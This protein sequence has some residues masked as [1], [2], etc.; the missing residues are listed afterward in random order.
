[1]KK[2]RN[3]RFSKSRYFCFIGIIA[4]GLVASLC[5]A[6]SEGTEVAESEQLGELRYFTLYSKE[7]G[8]SY[9]LGV[10][11]PPGYDK[12]GAP[13]PAVFTLDGA[14]YLQTFREWFYEDDNDII[15]VA[16][17]NT[18]RR[19]IDYMPPNDC[20]SGGGG[21]YDFLNFLVL[22]LVPYLDE[23]YN[24]DPSLRL[25][26]G[27]SHGGSFVF[28]TLFY[29]HGENFP[30]LLSTDASIDCNLRYF[31]NLE[32]SYHRTNNR[33]PVVLYAAAATGGNAKFVYPFMQN[34]MSRGYQGLVAKSKVFYGSHDG[35]LAQ[36]LPSGFN[37]IG[38]QID[39]TP[40]PNK[41][42]PFIPLLLLDN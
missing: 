9:R 42:M 20:T 2:A 41:A 23:N 21:N 22:E 4:L 26:F 8:V 10:A 35:I 28:Y 16:I 6:S 14:Y 25:L 37:W 3:E 15:I 19:N 31:Q 27:H 38:S 32:P 33:L 18:D 12:S 7:V 40:T 39:D 36:A 17:L 13:Y 34:L 29:D 5:P 24:I 30:L 1:M 11:T